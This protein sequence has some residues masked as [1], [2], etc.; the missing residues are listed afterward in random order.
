MGMTGISARA[1]VTGDRQAVLVRSAGGHLFV[2]RIRNG[3]LVAKL[4][5]DVPPKPD[6]A[7]ARGPPDAM[8][9][10]RLHIF[11]DIAWQH[12][13]YHLGGMAEIERL[14]RGGEIP[15]G[16]NP[17]EKCRCLG[18]WRLTNLG[19]P[20]DFYLGGLE[21]VRY[22]RTVVIAPDYQVLREYTTPGGS[23]PLPALLTTA[24]IMRDPLPRDAKILL[25][26]RR[27]V[28]SRDHLELGDCNE[29]DGPHAIHGRRPLALLGGQD[30][31]PAGGVDL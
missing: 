20:A 13:A 21:M 14:G 23:H 30:K 1:K 19:D 16:T 8:A 18:A 2:H 6:R 24:T 15:D 3:R 11:N 28:A 5:A 31:G 10:D 29:R 26:G 27:E 9:A 12:L 7:N 4:N 17:S 25:V 22:E